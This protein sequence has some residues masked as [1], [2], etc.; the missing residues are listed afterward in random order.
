MIEY[1]NCFKI[2]KYIHVLNVAWFIE[3]KCLIPGGWLQSLLLCIFGIFH[4]TKF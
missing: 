4:N 1:L 2:F 3:T